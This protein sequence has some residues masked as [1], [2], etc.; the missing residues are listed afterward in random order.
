MDHNAEKDLMG[1]IGIKPK[2]I[3]VIA[4]C[5]AAISAGLGI[6]IGYSEGSVYAG[7]RCAALLD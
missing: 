7:L 1:Y 4:G 6:V 5:C 3:L 2:D